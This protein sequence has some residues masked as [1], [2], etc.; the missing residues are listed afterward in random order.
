MVKKDPRLDSSYSAGS[1]CSSVRDDNGI[2][3]L[4]NEYKIT[5]PTNAKTP[6]PPFWGEHIPE[7]DWDPNEDFYNSIHAKAEMRRRN[8]ELKGK[9]PASK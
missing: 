3:F 7:D 2:L 1:K 4:D 6:P 9:P 8:Y 5:N